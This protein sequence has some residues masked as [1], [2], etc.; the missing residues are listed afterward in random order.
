MCGRVESLAQTFPNARA[1]FPDVT[2]AGR[3]DS[4]TMPPTLAKHTTPSSTTISFRF[5]P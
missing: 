3:S 1:R 5:V 2:L 4:L